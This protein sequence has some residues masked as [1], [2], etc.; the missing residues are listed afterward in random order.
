M[1]V[2]TDNN[3]ITIKNLPLFNEN[4]TFGYATDENNVD[5]ILNNILGKL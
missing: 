5:E 2:I 1:K 3:I 4:N